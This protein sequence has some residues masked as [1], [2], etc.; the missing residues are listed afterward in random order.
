VQWVQLASPSLDF[1]ILRVLSHPTS[2]RSYPFGGSS[3]AKSHAIVLHF[4]NEHQHIDRYEI[5]NVT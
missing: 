3:P 1:K 4:E 2:P 5:F